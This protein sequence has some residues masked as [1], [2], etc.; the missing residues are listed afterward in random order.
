MSTTHF[1]V[2]VLHHYTVFH[3]HSDVD[4]LDEALRLSDVYHA[5]FPAAEGYTI[6]IRLGGV[7]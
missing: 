1:V 2:E 4:T 7:R 6:K 3:R 5:A